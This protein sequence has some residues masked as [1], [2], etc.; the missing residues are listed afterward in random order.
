M[1]VVRVTESA[2]FNDLCFTTLESYRALTVVFL[3]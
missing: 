3:W 2:S 1:V